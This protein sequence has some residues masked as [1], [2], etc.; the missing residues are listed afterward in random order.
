MALTLIFV[1][2]T[3][4]RKVVIMGL[5][6]VKRGQAPIVVKAVGSVGYNNLI[7]LAGCFMK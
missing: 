3:P 1:F 6:Q 7:F 5:D 4:L 2:K